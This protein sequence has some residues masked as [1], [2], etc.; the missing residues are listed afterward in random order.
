MNAAVDEYH[1]LADNAA[2]C[3]YGFHVIVTDPTEEQMKI[4]LPKLVQRGITSV[5][6]GGN[7][8]CSRSRTADPDRND[9]IFRYT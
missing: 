9:A 1:K 7:C 4:E 5:K 3:D 2:H 6:V 8:N